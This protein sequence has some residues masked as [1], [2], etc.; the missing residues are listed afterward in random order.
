M[1]NFRK[2]L[3]L[4][5]FVVYVFVPQSAFDLLPSAPPRSFADTFGVQHPPAFVVLIAARQQCQIH[6]MNMFRYRF[7]LQSPCKIKNQRFDT[8]YGAQTKKQYKNNSRKKLV[9]LPQKTCS[10]DLLAIFCARCCGFR[11][12]TTRICTDCCRS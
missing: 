11:E 7:C 10:F 3:L 9:F 2:F 1:F 6:S 5:P 12:K 4:Y 8:G